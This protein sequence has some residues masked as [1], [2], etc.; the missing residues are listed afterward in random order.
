MK[1]KIVL[2][3][4]AGNVSPDTSFTAHSFGLGGQTLNEIEQ[5]VE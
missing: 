1:V 3:D 5:A 2:C 4:N